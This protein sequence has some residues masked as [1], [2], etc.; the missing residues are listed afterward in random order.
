M[1]DGLSNWI[2]E[3]D[4]ITTPRAV[5]ILVS[6]ISQS[7][8]QSLGLVRLPVDEEDPLDSLPAGRH[9]I[10][11]SSQQSYEESSNARNCFLL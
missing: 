4:G 9:I 7:L 1:Q 2:F 10:E 6:H 8:G 5:S 11:D 3:Q